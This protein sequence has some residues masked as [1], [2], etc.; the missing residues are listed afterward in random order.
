MMDKFY[1]YCHICARDAVFRTQIAQIN[2]P[3]LEIKPFTWSLES[4]VHQPA[5]G[6]EAQI[7]TVRS[8]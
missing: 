6:A 4:C 3:K 8:V 5:N 2:N 7:V 1:H